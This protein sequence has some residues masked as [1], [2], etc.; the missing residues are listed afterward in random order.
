MKIVFIADAHLKGLDDP[1]QKT[2]VK[3]IERLD[4]V[5]T[6]VILGDLFDFWAGDNRVAYRNYLPLLESLV[7]LRKK[8]VK[9]IYLEGNHDFSMGSFFVDK[10]GASV[11]PDSFDL[12]VNG[13]RVYLSHGDTAAMTLG[14]RLWRGFLRS[15]VFRVIA[16]LATP[17]VVWKSALYLSRR[18]RNYGKGSLPIDSALREFA[19][20]KIND[21]FSAVVMAHSHVAGIHREGKGYYANPGPWADKM[22]YLVY[23]DGGF[24]LERWKGR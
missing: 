17:A 24:R 11:H 9:I 20:K 14:Y 7:A 5:D 2:L 19:R 23:D 21:G 4:G 22:H 10:L 3:F 15:P 16:L 13:K 6:L 1:Y 18:S 12:D 8:G